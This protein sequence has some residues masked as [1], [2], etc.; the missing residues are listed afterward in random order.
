[1]IQLAGQVPAAV[2][3]DMLGIHVSTATKLVA[4]AGGNWVSYAAM[5]SGDAP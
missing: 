3:A 4:P 2:L 1:M 5:R